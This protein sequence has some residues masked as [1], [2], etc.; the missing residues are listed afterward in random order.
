MRCRSLEVFYIRDSLS[1]TSEPIVPRHRIVIFIR[2]SR[3]PDGN[4]MYKKREWKKNTRK[5]AA[6]RR[7]RGG[8]MIQREKRHFVFLD[9][10]RVAV[11]GMETFV[12]VTGMIVFTIDA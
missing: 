2:L 12:R 6:T 1:R 11:G 5:Q 9:E 7:T 8:K 4:V 3:L 10:G